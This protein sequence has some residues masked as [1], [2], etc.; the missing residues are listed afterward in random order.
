MCVHANFN[1]DKTDQSLW[2]NDQSFLNETYFK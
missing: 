1:H 2:H